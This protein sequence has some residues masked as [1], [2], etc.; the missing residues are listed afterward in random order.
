MP[1]NTLEV[2]LYILP[3]MDDVGRTLGHSYFLSKEEAGGGDPI[4]NP[5]IKKEIF[6]NPRR[7]GS[8]SPQKITEQ[9]MKKKKKHQHPTID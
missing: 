9:K 1:Q 7:R 8:L 6:E 5:P 3:K 4:T 2:I